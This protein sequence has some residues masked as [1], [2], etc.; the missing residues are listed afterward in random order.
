MTINSLAVPSPCLRVCQYNKLDMRT[1]SSKIPRLFLHQYVLFHLAQL[2]IRGNSRYLFSKC[3]NW[4]ICHTHQAFKLPL[5]T[6]SAK[7]K[8]Y[9]TV[10]SRISS[11][12]NPTVYS[13]FL[14]KNSSWVTSG[15]RAAKRLTSV[16]YKPRH[17][18]LCN[19]LQL[20]KMSH[21]TV[22]S[23]S[24]T[25]NSQCLRQSKPKYLSLNHGIFSTAPFSSVSN[26][27]H[28]FH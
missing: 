6:F 7:L 28:T 23:R 13:S 25:S 14:R 17:D 4:Q 10:K 26:L 3:W 24:T 16:Q 20:C 9:P 2:F 12:S 8:T 11:R 15:K 19:T 1:F 21:K 18:I 27:Y 5:R 22:R